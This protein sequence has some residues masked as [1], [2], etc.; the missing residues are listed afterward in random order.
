MAKN[1]APKATMKDVSR[2]ITDIYKKVN[3]LI[4]TMNG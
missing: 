3:F 1:K 2:A 4:S